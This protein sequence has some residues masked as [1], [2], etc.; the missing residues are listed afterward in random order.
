MQGFAALESWANLETPQAN[1]YDW[2]YL[3]AQRDR[4]HAEGKPV[5]FIVKTGGSECPKWLCGP[6]L[7][8]PQLPAPPTA[9]DPENASVPWDPVMNQRWKTTFAAMAARY[10]CDPWVVGIY[11]AGVN[12]QWPEMIYPDEGMAWDNATSAPPTG[13]MPD[14]RFDCPT[15]GK[16]YSDAWLNQLSASVAA[17]PHT[18]ILNM[19]DE[20]F[21][22][23]GGPPIMTVLDAVVSQVDTLPLR[24][25]IGTANLGPA[26]CSGCTQLPPSSCASCQPK[27][28]AASAEKR[29][30]PIV[31]ELG[32]N[33]ITAASQIYPALQ[34]CHDVL[35]CRMVITHKPTWSDPA[36][37]AQIHAASANLWGIP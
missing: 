2:T 33:K 31:Y 29:T 9:K 14:P 17:A 30:S 15:G 5:I 3:D 1:S 34:V 21:N 32:P 27:Y 26:T 28:V 36:N 19:V 7:S 24:T 37:M 10:D 35:G 20:V 13:I 11:L 25:T 8:R 6:P 18:W 16:V 23:C 12:A 4:A 22:P